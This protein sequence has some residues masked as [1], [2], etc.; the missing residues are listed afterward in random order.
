M[1]L[2]YRQDAKRIGI[3]LLKII[4][5]ILWPILLFVLPYYLVGSA[6][7]SFLDWNPHMIDI[8]GMDAGGRFAYLGGNVIFSLFVWVFFADH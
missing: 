4:W 7:M 5:L 6:L 8:S 1:V 2:S 3:V